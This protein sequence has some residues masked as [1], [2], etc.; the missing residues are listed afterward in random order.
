LLGMADGDGPGEASGSSVGGGDR[1]GTAS[2]ASVPGGDM[3]V[4]GDRLPV[5]L[6]SACLVGVEC[7]HRGRSSPSAA[8]RALGLGARLIPVCPEVAGGLPTP[9]P[10]A[11]L[12]PDGR[13]RTK[14]GDDVTDAYLR[15][16]AHAVDIARAA[17]AVRAVL[18]AR[19]PSCGC[20][21]VYDGTFSGTLRP[22]LGITAAALTAAGL[23]VVVDED[24]EAVVEH[25]DC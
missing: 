1:V 24:V 21:Q 4:T 9:R 8:V 5:I 16:A 22:G 11:E 19:S 25:D 10:A 3:S 14:S 15:G 17:G 23:E 2:G 13:V 18:K 20:H 7:N 12:Q 6:V